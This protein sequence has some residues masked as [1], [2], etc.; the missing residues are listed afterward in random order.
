MTSPPLAINPQ[1]NYANYVLFFETNKKTPSQICN[2]GVVI[3]ENWNE[4]PGSFLRE[5]F[6]SFVDYNQQHSIFN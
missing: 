4:P 3:A 2:N 6:K 5:P 1:I